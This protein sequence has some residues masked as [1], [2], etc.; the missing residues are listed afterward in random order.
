MSLLIANPEEMGLTDAKIKRSL[1][2]GLYFKEVKD[3]R[4]VRKLY[5]NYC[6]S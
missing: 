5:L 3:L 1:K 2:Q 6:F 4:K